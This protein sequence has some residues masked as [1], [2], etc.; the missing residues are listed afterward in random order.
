MKAW[1]NAEDHGSPT[2]GGF[3][4][5]FDR[6]AAAEMKENSAHEIMRAAERAYPDYSWEIVRIPSSN[7]FVVEGTQKK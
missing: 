1:L 4:L 3:Q 6:K 2:A 5:V 7:F